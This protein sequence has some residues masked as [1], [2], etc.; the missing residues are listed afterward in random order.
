MNQQS[1]TIVVQFKSTGVLGSSDELAF[2]HEMEDKFKALLDEHDA[3]IVDGGQIG[4][5]TMEIFLYVDDIPKVVALVKD[6]L[7]DIELI[8]WAKIVSHQ[9]IDAPWTVEYP[10]GAEFSF[11]TWQ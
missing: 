5:G 10:E 8:G 2:R 11:W 9:S 6:F 7:T 3:G 1:F 4:A